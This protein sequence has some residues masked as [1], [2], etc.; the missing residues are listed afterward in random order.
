MSN[1]L[2]IFYAMV[3]VTI[4]SGTIAFTG[5][6]EIAVLAELAGVAFI[7]HKA[8]NRCE[9]CGS[10]QTETTEE[11]FADSFDAE[12]GDVVAYRHCHFCGAERFLGSYPLE[13]WEWEPKDF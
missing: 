9:S 12:F 5:H 10:W 11:F 6:P 13:T 8:L 7:A 1:K 4:T 3:I 2:K